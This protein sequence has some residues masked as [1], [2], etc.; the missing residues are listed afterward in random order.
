MDTVTTR[1]K[2]LMENLPG[3]LSLQT[4]TL[5]LLSRSEEDD[6]YYLYFYLGVLCDMDGAFRG[7]QKYRLTPNLDPYL[8]PTMRFNFTEGVYRVC[9]EPNNV[10][11]LLLGISP[12]DDSIEGEY[13]DAH[14]LPK[15]V[16]ERIAVLMMLSPEP[17]TEEVDGVGRRISETVFWVV[18]P[19]ER[20]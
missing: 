7:R 11:V 6:P 17:P 13:A 15:W 1:M 3:G 8:N 9:I 10:S 16:Q 5:I 20:A 19:S 4:A 14:A 2:E 12:V 18:A